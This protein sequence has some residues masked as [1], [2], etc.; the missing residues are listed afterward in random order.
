MRIKKVDFGWVGENGGFAREGMMS[1]IDDQKKSLPA[2]GGI[3]VGGSV[4]VHTTTK[5]EAGE[6]LK[7]W[8]ADNS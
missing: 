2:V 5:K 7:C 3:A 6:L 1:M 8:G 4:T